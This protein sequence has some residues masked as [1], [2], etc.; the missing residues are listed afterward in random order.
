MKIVRVCSKCGRLYI[1]DIHINNV[2]EDLCKE[3]G[4]LASMQH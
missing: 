1:Y 2:H 4:K 3:C